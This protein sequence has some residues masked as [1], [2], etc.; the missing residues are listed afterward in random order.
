MRKSYLVL[1]LCSISYTAA[2]LAP[3]SK[4][5][6][7]TSPKFFATKD[8]HITFN[9]FEGYQAVDI[10]RAKECAEN[11]GECS[12]QE[13]EQLRSNLHKE[14]M[15]NLVFSNSLVDQPSGETLGHFL[16]EEELDLQLAMLK[17][18]DNSEKSLFLVEMEA[19][20]ETTAKKDEMGNISNVLHLTAPTPTQILAI[21]E[22]V[23]DENTLETAMICLVMAGIMVLP[24]I[25]DH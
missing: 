7:T 23:M 24:F 12:V 22:S 19:M 20:Q 18:H 2:F 14:R 17:D 9:P 1:P 5:L 25:A 8:R 6:Q 21:E 3:N 16:L 15:Q 4:S 13:I 11:F 10:D